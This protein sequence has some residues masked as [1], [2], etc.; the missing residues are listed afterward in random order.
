VRVTI[1]YMATLTATTER[2][3]YRT[4]FLLRKSEKLELERLASRENISSAEVIRRFI[5]HGDELLKSKQ[6]NEV[7][8][9]ALKIISQAVAEAN[10]SMTR[11]IDKL[12]SLHLELAERDIR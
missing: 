10:E 5:K 1:A 12:D 8:E 4:V 2:A 9:A 6:E 3:T 11:T 7:I